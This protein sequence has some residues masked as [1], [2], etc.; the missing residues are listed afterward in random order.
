M[1][2]ISNRPYKQE[3]YQQIRTLLIETKP[4]IPARHNWSIRRWD[5]NFYHREMLRS[6]TE[7][8][9]RV[10]VWEST[11]QIIG[12]IHPEDGGDAYFQIHPDYRP[13]IE[14]EMLLWAENNLARPNSAGERQLEVFA[15][16]YD[17]PRRRLL[18]QHGFE[19][20]AYGGVTRRLR[21]GKRPPQHHSQSRRLRPHRH[22][23][24]RQL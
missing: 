22:P 4:L 7:M 23:A 16:E 13:D 10:H 2:A 24:Q 12:V 3:D 20:T 21:F 5:G 19:K 1:N 18:Q 15:F 8:A 6:Q 17:S 11:H 14:E 9:K